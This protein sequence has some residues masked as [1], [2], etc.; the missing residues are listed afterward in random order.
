MATDLDLLVRDKYDGDASRVTQEDRDRL[1]TGEPLA[2]VIG[3]APF[4]NLRIDLSSRPLIPRPE[5]EWWT[6]LLI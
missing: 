3:W 4:L 1:D 5:T 6:E 2:Y